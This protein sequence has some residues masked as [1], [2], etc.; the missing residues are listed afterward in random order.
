[1]QR[2]PVGPI[3]AWTASDDMSALTALLHL[4]YKPLLDSGLQ[5]LT[6]RQDDDTTAR[7]IGGGR[8]CW[9]IDEPQLLATVTL[10]PPHLVQGCPWYDRGDVASVGQL[11][12]HPDWQSAGL[13]RALMAHA[14]EAAAAV[15][16]AEL[17]IDTSE[18]AQHL[19]RW[20][21]KLGYRLVGHADWDVTN[22]RSVVMSKTLTSASEVAAASTRDH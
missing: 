6:G 7:R 19:I 21:G 4:A 20:Y 1:M 17:A 3:R 16:A 13:G 22:Y 9:V 5:Y 12:V 10:S 14:E 11:A 15:G 18:Q 2:Q 8:L